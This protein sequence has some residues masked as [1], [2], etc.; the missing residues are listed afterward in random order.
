MVNRER[1]G[2]AFG[3]IVGRPAARCAREDFR[4][5][6]WHATTSK[7]ARGES[8]TVRLDELPEKEALPVEQMRCSSNLSRRA[9]RCVFTDFTEV[10]VAC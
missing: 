5:F 6:S 2:P 8:L 4:S 10:T 7:K 3:S 9:R 1:I